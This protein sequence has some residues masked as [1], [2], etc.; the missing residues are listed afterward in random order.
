MD[1]TTMRSA[2][3][4][5]PFRLAG[6][7]NAIPSRTLSRPV[8]ALLE[9]I[10]A[11]KKLDK[12]Y[13]SLAPSRDEQAFLQQL[14][15]TFNINYQVAEEE[16]ARIPKTGPLVIVANHPFGAIEGIIMAAM[17]RQVRPDVKIMANFVLK[18]IP[19]VRDLF[20]AVNPFGGKGATR[21]NAAPMKEALQWLKQGGLLV[22]FP[23]GEVSH[24]KP[25]KGVEDSPWSRSIGRLI[26]LAEAPVQPVYF[27]G[28]NSL[29]FQIAGLMHPLLRTAMLPRELINKA[30]TTIPI[31]IGTVQHWGRLKEIKSD[32]ALI[33]YLRMRTYMLRN[34][35]AK[36]QLVPATLQ[37]DTF[38]IIAAVDH[39]LMRVEVDALPDAQHL[40]DGGNMQ[41]YCAYA[42][43]IPNVL[44]E[45]GRL[46]EVSFRAAGEGTG[47]PFDLDFYDNY[48]LHLFIWNHDTN[49]VVG[50]YRLGEADK[51]IAK[52]GLVGLYSYSLFKYSRRLI[53][54]LNPAL[55][56]GRSFVRQEY[57]KSFAPLLL[58]WKGIAA[59]VYR[60]P[61]YRK[62]FGPVSI[63]N[64]YQPASQK[65]LVDFLRASNTYPELAR[66]VKPRSP[67]KV[68][69]VKAIGGACAHINSIEDVAE[70]IADIESGNKGIPILLRQYLR[71]GGQILEF[72]VDDQFNDALDGLIMLDLLQTEPKTLARYMGRDEVA[73]FH[74]WHR[75][76]ESR[77][78]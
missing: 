76:D 47:K 40:V 44:R 24:L 1:V 41:V 57:Q 2:A 43:Q 66:L 65:L 27:H 7:L 78:A 49:E 75:G 20:V 39:Q 42:K 25:F 45:I 60:N 64:D 67:F 63:S 56:L 52:Q 13:S 29:L 68:K 18:R 71:L 22:V 77:C 37:A 33:D 6:T 36:G 31:R 34:S 69:P 74:A 11:L 26:Q 3:P 4:E 9:R 53:D 14:F 16:L 32:Q 30:N 12:L 73:R 17:L 58:L 21:S 55:E 51:I 61:H 8:E 35:A 23:A 50:A 62:L 10:F 46:R 15:E 72:N 19:E 70:L 48:Y 38:N 54:E 28:A 59:F 5:T